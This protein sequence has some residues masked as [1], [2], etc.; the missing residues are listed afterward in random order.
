[1]NNMNL[2]EFESTETIKK[3]ISL[4]VVNYFTNYQL[5]YK[6]SLTFQAKLSR[7]IKPCFAQ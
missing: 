3:T 4:Q 1:M 6:L 7:D 5:F 2:M